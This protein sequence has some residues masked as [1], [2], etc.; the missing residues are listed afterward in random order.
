MKMPKKGLSRDEVARRLEEYRGGDL[1]WKEGRAFGFTYDPGEEIQAVIKEAYMSFLSENTLYADV[2]PSLLALE[3]DVVAMAVN[4]L[5]GDEQTSGNFTAGGTESNMLT[6]KTARDYM[7][8][9]KPHITEPEVILPDTAHGSLHKAIK[10]LGLKKKIVPVDRN[11]FRADVDATRNAITPN[12]IMLIG[13][14]TSFAHGVVD[15]IRELGDLALEHD[16]LL[17]VDGCIGAFILPYFK[18]LGVDVP[19]FDLSVPGV[20]SISMDLHKFAYAAKGA[21]VI[22]YKNKD[23]RRFQLYAC[24]EW[25]GYTHIN[26]T[27]LSSKTAGPLAAAWAVLN[28]IGD[29]GYL[30]RFRQVLESRNKIIQ[31]IDEIEEL[32]IEGRPD[33]NM[34]AIASDTINV[35]A[36]WDELKD[37]GWH[38]QA[39]FGYKDTRKHLHISV[40]IGNTKWV[41][42]FIRDLKTCVERAKHADLDR[43]AEETRAISSDLKPED[44]NLET[45]FKFIQVAG[46]D[47]GLP[48]RWGKI[49]EMMN[50][51]PTNQREWLMIEYVNMLYR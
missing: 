27:L 31:A 32:F 4:H 17:H 43:V 35:Y 12:T 1:N 21:S 45:F 40:M 25:T 20:T 44:L 11:T 33:T 19:D 9:K 46:V 16:L 23:L 26:T 30:E 7:A 34:L 8:V 22:L 37:C 15:P 18:R 10:F 24:A 49:N 6:V 39:Q 41:K 29:E 3:N 38:L 2:Y 5:G 47:G 51:L 28:Y 50:A 48:D 13:S 14:A 36:L 42:D